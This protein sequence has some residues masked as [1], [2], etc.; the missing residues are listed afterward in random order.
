MSMGSS[1]L[2]SELSSEFCINYYLFCYWIDSNFEGLEF[3]YF[4][5]E[6][7]SYLS[8][9]LLFFLL[10]MGNGFFAEGHAYILGWDYYFFDLS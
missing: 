7:R 8:E 10:S 9:T 3:T 5:E 2:S 4:G 1:F 6:K